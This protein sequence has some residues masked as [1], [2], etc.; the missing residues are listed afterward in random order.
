MNTT[1]KASS[2]RRLSRKHTRKRRERRLLILITLSQIHAFPTREH[3]LLH[4]SHIQT[5]QP[6]IKNSIAVIVK[7]HRYFLLEEIMQFLIF[8]LHDFIYC[9]IIHLRYMKIT[10]EVK[11]SK[12]STGGTTQ[13]RSSRQSYHQFLDNKYNKTAS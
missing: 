3:Q 6:Q 13:T 10:Q 5:Q 11:K 8:Y 12:T 2:L 1:R 7:Y 4:K 9:V